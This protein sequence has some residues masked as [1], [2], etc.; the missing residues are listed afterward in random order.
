MKKHNRV[1]L[2]DFSNGIKRKT[3]LP[4]IWGLCFSI[5]Y[6]FYFSK[7]IITDSA[8]DRTFVVIAILLLLALF[9]IFRWWLGKI[10]WEIIEKSWSIDGLDN[11]I[12]TNSKGSGLIKLLVKLFGLKNVFN[13]SIVFIFVFPLVCFLI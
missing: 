8:T 7:R 2:L 10:S 9:G 13:G 5:S 4:Y 1:L 6:I 3:K 12:Q 11:L